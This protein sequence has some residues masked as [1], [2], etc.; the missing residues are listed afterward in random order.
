MHRCFEGANIAKKSIVNLS[1]TKYQNYVKKLKNFI[2]FNS[3]S[4]SRRDT[5]YKVIR[6]I[7]YNSVSISPS[8]LVACMYSTCV[9][10]EKSTKIG[11]SK[12]CRKLCRD[13]GTRKN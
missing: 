13:I 1:H 11:N 7:K 6:V 12:F 4:A 8:T 10:T 5:L 3:F 9:G 2:F